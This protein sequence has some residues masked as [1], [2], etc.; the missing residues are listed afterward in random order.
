MPMPAHRPP[1]GRH[2]VASLAL[3]CAANVAQAVPSFARQTG[4][5]CMTCHLSW[6]ELTPTGRQFKL[7]GYTLGERLRLP[8]AGMVQASATSTANVDPRVADSFP[9]DRQATL[10]QA[11]IFLSG[12]LTDHVGVFSQYSYDGVE[13]HGSIDNVDLRYANHAGE[14][15]S[16]LV[17]GFTLHNNPTVQDVYNTGPAWGFPYAS[18]PVAAAPN[19]ATAIDS[20]GQQ[21]AGLGAYALWRDTVYGELSFYRTADGVFSPLRL[22]TDHAE[23][24][25]LKGYAP[26]WRLAL[27]HDWDHARHSAMVGAYGLVLD[28]YPDNTVRSGPTDHYRD[29]GVDAQY[30]YLTDR[31]RVSAQLNYVSERARIGS[32]S[33]ASIDLHSLRA[34][35]TYYF[36]KKYGFSVGR[37]ATH[38]T[39]DDALY[40]SGEPVS[41]SASGSPNSAGYLWEFDYLPRRDVRFMLQYTRYNR[42]NGAAT[43]YDG[44]GRNARDNNSLYLMLW[45]MF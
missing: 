7:N 10:Q 5:D 39:A 44:Q 41:G 24:A 18:S 36:D 15:A 29:L 2:I 37:F 13:H 34:K 31:H 32:A 16:K 40:Y 38:G 33:N 20:L 8:L 6:P 12:K 26:Y 35:A 23:D 30:Q 3:C 14:A 11:S 19:A 42:F 28:R 25:A 21:V 1:P 4:L 27:Q 45:L 43:N 17:Y 22:G 9:K